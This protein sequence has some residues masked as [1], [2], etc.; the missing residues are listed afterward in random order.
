MKVH[1]FFPSEFQQ[2]RIIFVSGHALYSI[3]IQNLCQTVAGIISMGQFHE[4]SISIFFFSYSI[5]DGIVLQPFLPF[6]VYSGTDYKFW[7]L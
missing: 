5:M 2:I 4:Y 3:H 6:N 1:E 7:L